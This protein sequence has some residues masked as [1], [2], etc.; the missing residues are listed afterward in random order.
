MYP[1]MS[2]YKYTTMCYRSIYFYLMH[3]LQSH[4]YNPLI[5]MTETQPPLTHTDFLHISL[6]FV[7]F[8]VLMALS[9]CVYEHPFRWWMNILHIYITK[10]GMMLWSLSIQI[11]VS[12]FHHKLTMLV[13]LVINWFSLQMKL[14]THKGDLQ[15]AFGLRRLHSST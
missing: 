5:I 6:H 9:L 12:N 10:P 7:T 13:V 8:S 11:R 15:I 1:P 14:Q 3:K 2:V 4:E